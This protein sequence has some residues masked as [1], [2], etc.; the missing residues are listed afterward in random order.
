MTTDCVCD[1]GPQQLFVC[2]VNSIQ[3]ESSIR[4]NIS[5]SGF[6]HRRPHPQIASLF[7]ERTE[8]RCETEMKSRQVSCSWMIS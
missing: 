5:V 2:H 8:Q 3:S 6:S 1:I 7:S 4:V